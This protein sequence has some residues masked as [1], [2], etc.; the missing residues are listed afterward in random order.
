MPSTRRLV[1][2]DPS[3]APGMGGMPAGRLLP[4]SRVGM[5]GPW[6]LVNHFGPTDTR[7]GAPIASPRHPHTGCSTV[8]WLFSGAIEHVDS[9]GNRIRIT[10]GEVARLIAGRGVSHAQTAD[11]TAPILHGV[12][13]WL[14]LP[15]H[16]RHIAPALTRYR[17][18]PIGVDDATV[19]LFIG[20]WLG[21]GAPV[22]TYSPV[23]GAEIMLPV[24]GRLARELAPDFAHGVLVDRPV[25]VNGT[26]VPANR[27]AILP[28]GTPELRMEAGPEP[29]RAI[30]LGG[31]P[32]PDRVI[33]WWTFLGR[34]HAEIADYRA[35]WQAEI[36]AEPAD[37]PAS[38]RYR[39]AVAWPRFGVPEPGMAPA[40][41]A[42]P[43]NGI[44]RPRRS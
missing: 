41:P 25:T 40:Q 15:E 33:M 11:P 3:P 17:P 20:T 22:L 26:P 35:A 10:P 1:V 2:V 8:T 23:V 19:R 28:L 38:G 16:A 29:V 13:L 37:P 32:L 30:L 9:I 44:L 36:G 6:C 14:A 27:L 12:H 31:R 5:I 39:D 4:N 21:R 7:G 42:P 34:T 43:L 24:R 18:D